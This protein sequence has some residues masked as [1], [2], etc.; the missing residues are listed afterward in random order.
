MNP[1][2]LSLRDMIST[3]VRARVYQT[4]R[5]DRNVLLIRRFVFVGV[6]RNLWQSHLLQ[7]R[8]R[9]VLLVTSWFP[10]WLAFWRTEQPATPTGPTGSG[11]PPAEQGDPNGPPTEQ[12][13]PKHIS[14]QRLRKMLD[15]SS[16]Y[17]VHGTGKPNVGTCRI[18]VKAE[19]DQA[20]M[21]NPMQ[22]I[23]IY[24]FRGLTAAIKTGHGPYAVVFRYSIAW[25][26][27]GT[28][29]IHDG[30]GS[31]PDSEVVG[32]FHKDDLDAAQRLRR[33]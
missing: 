11:G 23:G 33:G 12:G 21:S 26:Q 1:Q 8:T 25:R 27:F 29:V 15:S 5:Q 6:Y 17:V 31:L 18:P 28:A 13:D 24:G 3:S 16:D 2:M 7:V 4:F 14:V 19:T 9:S 10:D 32:W 20:L 30:E 22:P